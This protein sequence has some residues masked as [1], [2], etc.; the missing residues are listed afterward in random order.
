MRTRE[1]V[2]DLRELHHSYILE[3]IQMPQVELMKV[4]DLSDVNTA[5][6]KIKKYG[7]IDKEMEELQKSYSNLYLSLEKEAIANTEFAIGYEKIIRTIEFKTAAVIEAFSVSI[8]EQKENM[9]SIKLP[10]YEDLKKVSRFISDVENM[11]KSVIPSNKP[12]SIKLNNFDTGSNWIE[13]VLGKM[14]DVLLIAEFITLCAAFTKTYGFTYFK[15]KKEIEQ[16]SAI[17]D[18]LKQVMLKGLEQIIEEKSQLSIKE[19]LE[20]GLINVDDI[21]TI[22]EYKNGLNVQFIKTA[23]YIAEGAEYRPALNAP[24]GIQEQFPK[25]EDYKKIQNDLPNLF[26]EHLDNFNEAV[27]GKSK[28]QNDEEKELEMDKI[29]N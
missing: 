9:I 25:D 19:L 20:T 11:I 2:E 26:I 4:T 16:T 5:I 1:M 7:F 24:Q 17:D 28:V 22:E 14:E 29:E 12:T 27:E 23:T 13:I 3:V 8:E 6:N 21:S 18:E 15:T 10:P